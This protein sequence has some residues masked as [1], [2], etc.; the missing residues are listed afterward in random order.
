MARATLSE[1]PRCGEAVI[2]V[3]K[4]LPG[5]L[6]TLM[7]DPAPCGRAVAEVLVEDTLGTLVGYVIAPGDRRAIR[8]DA[9]DRC[10][11]L[12]RCVEADA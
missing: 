7:V 3:L 2:V 4:S 11:Q 9:A 5:A 10:R 6:S 12:H 8:A 1:C